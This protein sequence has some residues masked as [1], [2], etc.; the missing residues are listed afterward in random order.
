MKIAEKISEF[1]NELEI[2]KD[3]QSKF[4]AHA[5]RLKSMIKKTTGVLSDLQR[6]L[7]MVKTTESVQ[8]RQKLLQVI[9]LQGL[10]N[11]FLRKNR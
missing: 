11:Y 5:Q 9:M 7:V 6:Q 4:A 8:K 1:Q 2:Q 3:A 10:P